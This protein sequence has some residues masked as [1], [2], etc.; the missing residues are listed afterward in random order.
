MNTIAISGAYGRD[1][2]SKKKM[3]EDFNLEKDFFI[4]TPGFNSYMSKRDLKNLHDVS[5]VNSIEFRYKNK[6]KVF[7]LNIM[8]EIK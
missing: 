8:K 7:M 5:G 3:L 4:L 2:T 6:T 1:Y